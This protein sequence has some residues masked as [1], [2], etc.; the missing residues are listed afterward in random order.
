MR[1]GR[2]HGYSLVP[3]LFLHIHI[4]E[5]GSLGMRLV[6]G[7][8][9]A[10]FQG[11]GNKASVKGEYSFFFACTQGRYSKKSFLGKCLQQVRGKGAMNNTYCFTTSYCPSRLFCVTGP[12]PCS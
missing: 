3:R 11:P 8:G 2:R 4:Q 5:P 10:L 12:P 7:E 6:K 1:L 9:V